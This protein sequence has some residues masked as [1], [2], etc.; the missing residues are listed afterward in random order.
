MSPPFRS[1][2]RFFAKPINRIC[3]LPRR[4]S[5]SGS[6]RCAFR[7]PR[8]HSAE[9]VRIARMRSGREVLLRAPAKCFTE[10][11]SLFRAAPSIHHSPFREIIDIWLSFLAFESNHCDYS[12]PLRPFVPS[13]SGAIVI[14][15]GMGGSWWLRSALVV[16]RR[17]YVSVGTRATLKKYTSG[18]AVWLQT[19]QTMCGRPEN[20]WTSSPF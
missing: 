10:L 12:T 2:R 4:I 17:V 16:R 14:A 9:P 13:L 8:A 5:C 20:V 1:G 15:V 11:L 19:G 18:T 6:D 7:I 3:T